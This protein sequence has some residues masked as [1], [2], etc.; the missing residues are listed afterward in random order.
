MSNIVSGSF[1]LAPTTDKYL[2]LAGEEYARTLSIGDDWTR[3]RIGMM[4]AVTPDGTNN[5]TSVI[6]FFGLCSGKTAPFG[7]ASTTHAVGIPLQGNSGLMTARNQTYVAGSGNPYFTQ[8]NSFPT[9][10]K[11][12]ATTLTNFTG[13]SSYI[14]ALPAM[15]VGTTVRRGMIFFE[16]EKGSPYTIRV[17]GA[18]NN[19]GAI[20]TGQVL[21][22]DYSLAT[23]LELIADPSTV[24]LT[25]AL[26]KTFNGQSVTN[27]GIDEATDGSLDTINIAWNKASFPLVVYAVAAYKFS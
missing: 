7:A 21:Y 9:A 23:F 11:R 22:S 20:Q 19:N 13:F 3:L 1:V 12:V 25:T 2:T 14:Y 17:F 5:I 26:G 10:G 15:G 27:S 24:N 18:D 8:S 4:A 6:G 16:I